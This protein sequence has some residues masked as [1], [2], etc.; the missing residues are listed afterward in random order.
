MKGTQTAA[1]G[2]GGQYPGDEHGAPAP[3][4][5]GEGSGPEGSAQA[6]EGGR[7][8]NNANY[9]SKL[10]ARQDR[11]RRRHELRSHLWGLSSLERVRKCGRVSRADGVGLRIGREGAGFS[12]LVSCGSVWGCPVCAAKI[13]AAR[14]T[15]LGHVLA[16]AADSGHTVALLTLTM[17]HHREQRLSDCWDAATAGWS[18]V[19][20]GE[21]WS[22][23]K[24][25]KFA[26]RLAKWESDKAGNWEGSR[27]RKRPERRIGDLEYFGVLGYARAVETTHGANGWHVHLHVALIL[28]GRTSDD[29]TRVRAL[30]REMFGRWASGLAKRGFTALAANGGMDVRLAEG[31]TNALSGYLAKQLAVETTHGHAKNGRVGGR[32]PF[33][34][35]ESVVSSGNADDLDLWH[36]WEGA[37]EGRQQLTWS[38]GLREMAGLAAEERSEEDIVDEDLGGDDLI[39]LDGH[40]WRLVRRVQTELLDAAER[41]G[42]IGAIRWLTDRG[43]IFRLME[44]GLALCILLLMK[45]VCVLAQIQEW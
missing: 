45:H 17:R 21:R 35:L 6:A 29:E 23:E 10:E 28:E 5:G 25:A 43:I 16:W 26:H 20:S 42:L 31:A 14:A 44:A 8:G 34:L 22:G 15:D 4:A 32:T 38:S 2:L 39:V 33:Q 1:V 3:R 13:A 36:E 9:S 40:S 41:A 27:A 7:L 37:S 24:P 19:T 12:G 30:G 11:R 18:R